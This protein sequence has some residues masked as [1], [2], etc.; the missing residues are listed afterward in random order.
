MFAENWI[1]NLLFQDGRCSQILSR[2]IFSI[3]LY[4]VKE[5]KHGLNNCV[6]R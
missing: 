5:I 1:F 3:L 4:E 2:Q 6:W